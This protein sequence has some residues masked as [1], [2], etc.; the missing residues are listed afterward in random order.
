[1]ANKNNPL[2][3]TNLTVNFLPKFYQ[4]D[5]NKK[6]L[7]ATLDQL[8]QP[9]SIKKINGFVGRENAKSSTGTDIYI[10]ASDQVRQDYQLEPAITITDN[11]GNQTFFK[12]YI[13]YINQINTFGGNTANH[14]R[15]NKQEFYSWDPHIDWD[16]FVNFQNYYWVPYGPDTIRIQGQQKAVTSTYT[17][18]IE[19]ELSNNEY[20]FT[21][22]GFTRNPVLKLYR[23]QTYTFEINSPSNPFSIKTARTP[24]QADRYLVDT[25]DNHGVEIGT[26]T[27]TVPLD[28][29]T[30][31]FYQSESDLQL[32]GAIQVLSITADTYIDVEN[33]L[34]GKK[35]Y[36]LSNGTQLSNGMKLAFLGNVTPT[37]YASGEFFVEGVGVAIKLI[38][39]SR[40]EII[41]PYTEEKT[42]PFDSDKFD[43]QPFS[44]ATGYAGQSDYIVIDRG[45]ND[46][47]NWSR[48][49]RWFHKD[50]IAASSLYNGNPVNLDQTARAIRPIIEFNSDLKLANFGTTAIADVDVIDDY[51]TDAFS[52]IEGSFAYSVDG[53]SLAEGQRVIFTADPDILVKNKVFKVTFVNVLHLNSGS[54]QIHL[55][56]IS[57]PVLNQVALIK[58]GI[59]HQGSAFWYNGTTWVRGQLKTKVNQAPLFDV[60][61]EN[62]ISYGDNS[63]YNGSTFIG[64]TLFSYKLG[65]GT[66]DSALGFPLSYRNISNIGDIVFNF[67]LATD[68]FQYKQG[69]AL[70]TQAINVGY[71]VGQT[72]AGK[73]TY[74]NGW[75][76]CT[77]TNTQAAIRIYKN[78]GITNYFNIDIFDDITNLSDLVV[79]IY[80]N[81]H[82]LDPMVWTLID[83]P[84]YKQVQ[85]RTDIALSD[86]LTIRAFAA[87]PINTV[88]YYEIPVNLQNNPLNDIMGDFTLGEVSD[89]VNSIVDNLDTTFVGVFPGSGNLRDLGNV[90]QYGTKFV[91]HSGPMSLAIYHITSESNNVIRSVQQA[92]DDYNNFKRNFIKIASSLGVDGDTVTI[93]NLVLQK[94][95]KD[96]PK[97][98]PY[99]FSDMVPYGACVVTDLNV[100]DYRIKQ[101]PLTK[102]F[103]LTALSN[104]A[105]GV[106]LNGVQLVYEQDYRFLDTGFV[107]IDSSVNMNT[108]D[109][110]TTREY[111]STDGCFVPATPTKMGIW[112]K[113]APTIYTD[114]SLVTPRIMIQGHD[115]SQILAYGD[116]RDNLILELEKRIFNN[117]KVQYDT[118]IFDVTDIIPGYNRKTDYSLSEFNEVL[119]PNFY[120]WTALSGRDFT[121][122]LGT[123]AVENTFTYNYS[124]TVGPDGNPVPGYWRGIYRWLLDTDRPNL[125]PWE[126]LGFSIEPK[127][128]ATVYGV[129][130]YTG[131]NLPMWQDISDGMVRE[132]GVPAVKLNKYVKPFLMNHIPVDSNGTLLSPIDS[133]LVSGTTVFTMDGGFVF[134]DVNP[135]EAAWRRS[136]HYPFSILISAI[137][138][139]PA[140]TFGLLLD[141]ANIKRN[142]AGQLIYA[143]TNLR[144]RPTDIMLPSI[145]SSAT[146]V[147]TAGLVNYIVDHILNFVF[148][149]NIRSY[150]QYATDLDTLTSRISYRVGAFT[151]KEQFNL[152]LDS[153]TPLSTGSVFIPQEN[154]QVNINTS[155]P[156]KKITYSGVIITKLHSGYEVKGYSTTQPYFKYYPYLQTGQRI[157]VGG[158]SEGYTNWTPGQQY[159]ANSVILYKGQYYR[160]LSSTT[161]AATFDPTAFSYLGELPV[162][163]GANAVLRKL[164]D[165]NKPVVVP[166][167][168][169][170]TKIQ[171]VVDFLQGYGEWLTD[172]GFVFDDFNSNLNAV[173]NWENSAREFL[174][175]TTQNWNSGADT[176]ADWTP[177]E[178]VTYGTIVKY[179]GDYYSALYNIAATD[180]FDPI[181][182]SKLEGLSNVGSSVISLSPG[183][184]KLTFNT[185][186]AVVDNISNQ[187]YE[188]EIFKVDGTPL[189]P[190]F[191]DSYRENN[192]V[193]Y[194][195]RTTDGIY[196][197]SFYLIQNEHVVTIDNT[198][199]F[200]DV[201]YNPQSGY[202]QERIKVSGHV[203]IDWYGGLDVPG[204]IFDQANIKQWQ[205]WQDYALGD[206]VN[207]QGFYY[208]ALSA[209]SGTE[210]F[211]PNNW[212]QLTTKPTPKL[213]P[214]WTYKASQFTDF[215]SLDDDNFDTAQQNMAHHLIGYQKRQYLNN[216]IQDN[217]SEFKFF[218]GMIREKGTQNSLNKLFDV[219]SSDNKE[220]LK[221]YEEWAVRAGQYGASRAF[222]NIEFLLDEGAFRLNPQGF[223]LVT[224]PDVNLNGTFIIQ[225]KSTDVYLK[226]LGYDTKPWPLLTNY[227]PF[228]RSAGYVNSKEVSISLGYLSEIADLDIATINEGAYIW[229]AFEGPSWNLYRYTDIHMAV[230]NVTYNDSSKILTITAQ[231]LTGFVPGS[232]IG[233]AQVEK[234]KGFYQIISVELNTF[235]V[236]VIVNS[237]PSPFNQSSELVV[238]ALISQRTSSIDTLDSV[239][240]TKLTPGELIWTDDSGNGKWASW[241]FN[242]TYTIS[243]V[244]N[245]APQN[246]LR[247]GNTIAMNNKGTLA[248]VGSS[249]GE[250]ITYDKVGTVTPWVQRQIV[251]SPFIATNIV[252]L[253]TGNTVLNSTTVTMSS[254]NA[255]MV[256][257]FIDGPG[258][259]YDTLVTAVNNGISITISQKANATTTAS[260]FTIVTN[261]NP[262][263]VIATSIAFSADGTWMASGSPLAGY[264]VT[265]F[266]GAYNTANVY[267][268]GLIVSTGSGTSTTY[269]QALSNVPTNKPPA[270]NLAY[271]TPIYYLPVDSYGTWSINDSYLENTLVVYKSKVYKNVVP[272]TTPGLPSIYGQTTI[273]VLSTNGASYILTADTTAGL[274]PNYQIIFTGNVFGGILSGGLYYVSTVLSSTTFTITALQYSTSLAPVTTAYGSMQAT[275]Q[276]QPSPGGNNQW[277]EQ[278]T[279]AGPVGQGVISLYKKDPNNIYGLVDT[280]ISPFPTANE[281]FGSEIVFGNDTVYVS[282]PGYGGVGRVYK[283]KYATTIQAQSAYNPVGSTNSTIVVTSTAGVRAGMYVINPAFTSEQTVAQVLDS[284]TVILSGSPNSIPSGIIKFAIVGWG[285][286]FTEI[287]SGTQTGAAFGN[288]ISLSQDNL[289]LAIGADTGTIN[290]VL[291]IYKNTGTGFNPALPLISIPGTTKNFGIS[292]SISNDGTYIAV[293]DDS[294]TVGGVIQRGGVTVYKFNGTTYLPY[295]TLI[296]HQPEI[297][298]HFGNKLSFMNDYETLVVYSQYGDTIITTTFDDK[299]TTFDK[300]STSFVFTQTNSGRVD[301][302]DLYATKWV[303][304]ESLT[305]SN[306]VKTAG[307]FIRNNV[308][309]ILT[310]GTTDFTT[311]GASTNTIGVTFTAT[312]DGYGT[313]TAALVTNETLIDDG[314]GVGFAVGSNHILIGAPESIDQGFNSGKVYDYGKPNNTYTWTIDHSEVDKPDVTKIKQAF[315]YNRVTGELITHL[316]VIDIA[317]GKIPG[318]ADEEIMYKAFYDPAS[319]STVNGTTTSESSTVWTTKQVGQLWWDVRTA[320][321]IDAYENDPVY[322]NTNWNTL[323]TG[324]SIDIYEWVETKLK[325]SVW[326][327]QADTPAGLTNNI[328]G[329]SLYGDSKY[330]IKTTYNTVTLSTVTTYYFWVKNR[331]FTPSVPGRYMSAQDVSSLIANPRGQGYTYLALTGLDSFS[332]V[333]AKSYLK[334]NEVVL[335]V[336]YWTGDK[337]DQ[338]VHS[339]WN[340]ISDDP[341]TYIPLPIEQKWIDSLCGK[342]TAGREVPDLSLPVKLR[343]GIENRPRQGMFVNR[344]E[345][346]KQFVET[347]NQILLANQIVEEASITALQGYDPQPTV[348]SGLYDVTFPTDA[349]LVYASTGSFTRAVIVP[350]VADGRVTGVIVINSGK[351]YLVAPY[352]TIVGVGVGAK[353]RA[354]IN[355]KGQITG[356]TVIASGE[357]YSDTT[358]TINVRDYC[359]LVQSDSQANGNWSIYSYD[360]TQRSWARILTQSYDVRQ[361]WNYADW[362]G[363]YTDTTGKVIFTASQ[364]TVAKFSVATLTDLNGIQPAI[365]DI[366]KVRTTNAGGWELLYKYSNSTS[367]DWT[368]SY[369]TVGIQNGTIQLSSSLYNLSNTDLGFDNTIYDSNSYDKVASIE[370]RIILDTLKNKIFTQ[371]TSLNGAYSDLFFASVRYALSEQPYVDWIFKTSFVKAQHN[372]GP[373]NQPVTYQADN[374]ANFE[375]YVNEVKP[376]KTKVREYVSNYDSLDPAQ[377]PI[378]DFDLQPI[379]QNNALAVIDTF[380]SNGKLAT[381]NSIVQQYPW[382]FW[383]D[384]G[385]FEV[386]ELKLTSSGSKY[387]TE[388]QVIITSD[389]GSGA[390]A[391]AFISNEKINRIVLLTP[392]SGYLSAPKV[393]IRGGTLIDGTS[394]TASAI[395][396]NSVV[397]GT[398]VGIKFD[399]I[400]STYF[401]TQQS[402][403]E[404]FTGTGSRQQF[405]LVWGPDIKIGQSTVYIDNILALRDSYVM[406]VVKSTSLGY[407]TYSGIIQFDTAPKKGSSISVTYMIDPSL[408]QATDR[409]QYLYNSATGELG[410]DLSQ[411]MTGVDY[412]GVIVDGTGFQ[413]SNGWDSLPYYSDQWDSFDET[414]NDYS[415]VVG[416]DTHAFTLPYTP[417]AGVQLTLY[418][419]QS[420][421]DTY[422][423]DGITKTYLYSTADVA[424]YVT[425]ANNLATVGISAT[426][427][428]INRIGS[429]FGTILMISNTAGIVAG[430]GVVGA[431]F[432]NG[433]TVSSVTNST[434]LVLSIPADSQ[435]SGTIQFI[436]NV[437]GSATLNVTSTVALKPGDVVTLLNLNA[438]SYNTTV[439]SIPNSTTVT[440]SNIIYQTIPPGTYITF[441]RKLIQPTDVTVKTDGSIVLTNL[442]NSKIVA[443]TLINIIGQINPVRLDDP[444]Y[445]IKPYFQ[446]L[447]NAFA[448]DTAFTTGTIS[449]MQ[450]IFAGLDILTQVKTFGYDAVTTA[451]SVTA[452]A[453]TILAIPAVAANSAAV[454]T[455]NTNLANIVGLI[456]QDNSGIIPTPEFPEY[457]NLAGYS[458]LTSS[459]TV[460]IISYAQGFSISFTTN[461]S[462]GQ[463]LFTTGSRIRIISAANSSNYLEGVITSYVGTTLVFSVD[464]VS[465]S[466]TPSSWN[467]VDI[468]AQSY[469]NAGTLL[470]DNITFIQFEMVAYITANYPSATYDDAIFRQDIQNVV[471]S[472][473]YDLTYGGNSQSVQ[474]GLR[475]WSSNNDLRTNLLAAWPG[476]YT[477]LASIAQSVITKST[478]TR[479]QT[480]VAQYKPANILTEGGIASDSVSANLATIKSIV[481]AL[482]RPNITVTPPVLTKALSALQPVATAILN[483]SL[484][485]PYNRNAIVNTFLSNGL[486]DNSGVVSK[487]FTI[488][489]PYTLI[490]GGASYTT[491][492]TEVDDGGNASSSPTVVDDGGTAISSGFVVSNL[493][494]FTIRQIT[495]DGSIKP[496]ETDY[497]TALNGGDTSTTLQGV[498]AT[499]TGLNA[500]DII[501]DGDDLVTTTSSPAPEE[502]VPGQVVD[503]VAIKVFDKPYNGSATMR[504]DNFVANGTNKSFALSQTP[505][506]KGAVI[507]KLNNT[508]KTLTTDY[509]IDYR[510]NLVVF[511][512][513]PAANTQVSLFSVGFNGA[514]ILDIDHFVSNGYSTEIVS[515]ATWQENISTLVY[516]DG[517]VVNPEIFKTDSSYDLSNSIAFRFAVAPA[518]NALI[519]F[520]IVAGDQQ[521]FAITKVE[522]VATN[523][524]LTY[525]LQNR[526]GDSLPAES[527]MIVRVDQTILSAPNNSYFTIGGNRLNYSIDSTKFVPYS[528]DI[529]ALVVLVGGVTLRAGPDYIADLGGITIK[530]TRKI[531]NLY[532]GQTLVISVLTGA[533]YSY[534]STTGQITFAQA[535]DNT[536]VV[537]VISSYQHD[538][539]NIQRTTVNVI[540][541]SLLVPNSANYFY[542]QDTAGGLVALDRPVISDYYV[543][544]IKNSLLLTP[545]VDYK[546]ND[547]HQSITLAKELNTNDQITLMTFGSDILTPGIAYMQFKDMLNRVSYKRL[548]ISKQ[549]T[550]ANDLKWND[551]AIVLADAS[552]FEIPSP[553]NNKPGVVEIRGE[554]IEYFVKSGNTLSQLRRGTLGTGVFFNNF[555][556]TPVQDIGAG[557]TI[558]YKDTQTVTQII[559]DG[560]KIIPLDFVPAS[561]NAIEVFVGG[562][563]TDNEWSSGVAYTVGAIVK[564]GPYTYRCITAHTS[565]AFFDDIAKWTFFIG[566]IRLKKTPYKVFNINNAPNSPAGDV[567]FP[568]DFTVDGVTKQITLT[569]LLDFGIQVTVVQNTGVAWDN[570]TSVLYDAGKIS[571]FLRAE[572]G[573]WHTPYKQISITATGT[574]D[575]AGDTLDSAN[576]T[577]DQG[578]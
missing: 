555:A 89:H 255:S 243:D 534:N 266:L 256:G 455:I 530:L 490:D 25:I 334:S 101:Y 244:N 322:R 7:Q 546:L 446:Q 569:N 239:L 162:V 374:L 94:I 183:A 399:R 102:P 96:K 260:T 313:G 271:W 171:D 558:P 27:F 143:N 209:L 560:N 35:H 325:P 200:N 207:N 551:T 88:G 215:Y 72:F 327:T 71:L 462:A 258:V 124:D 284:R 290:G 28:A 199:I 63:V 336:E 378:T 195:P 93:T 175:W 539:L 491:L 122:P 216:I 108:G 51:T 77:A 281:N 288:S 133:G 16:K 167:G 81:G 364:F 431:G 107:V 532:K 301:I 127:W 160:T 83:T 424:P 269:W 418:R 179:N 397:R 9:G 169:E 291:N 415:V 464:S 383:L 553:A 46:A 402:K 247:F 85:L 403:T 109:V 125:C 444:N 550:L 469:I 406:Y 112:P 474:A 305:K 184:N 137:L 432:A 345:A 308:Y 510:N 194:S 480:A 330:S 420:N 307:N 458:G 507:V 204:F 577:F 449:N 105:V 310:L 319:Y 229:V 463:T 497:D 559:S 121:K 394:A 79:R 65:S 44:D 426:F 488:P 267:G 287:Y 295:Q 294:A 276:P 219:L 139:N 193:S 264:A 240:T 365:G 435:P 398:M 221:F 554:R 104:D 575:S 471:W 236:S 201:V 441:T 48:Y 486:P 177:A 359:A 173:S 386:I 311:I 454:A 73:P 528:V 544:V 70:L 246:Q 526:I 232:W 422:Q 115:G 91:Q 492:D 542:Y 47:N 388:P 241:M 8:Y 218:Q 15:L 421:T 153:K 556:G 123:F 279:Q 457:I 382:K 314:Y 427:T 567:T 391:R 460:A 131:D 149:N 537:Q 339:H 475:Y 166:Y 254:A 220:S 529:T 513:A 413:I 533:G 20:L 24:G 515:N 141:R 400:N 234:L 573:I 504:V 119:A 478:V 442:A 163:G 335:S 351:G 32:G 303:F 466:G 445:N 350:V 100:V 484:V 136:S 372:V 49:N 59:K 450:S 571:E 524:A 268:P 66:N 154:Y 157:N 86:V 42:I 275:Q 228:L 18:S 134:G 53:V 512:T 132:P 384:N 405:L 514:N 329:K 522:T 178:P 187:F 56:E 572:A 309:Q 68:T 472:L 540:G 440:L 262:A 142:R 172:Q 557:E 361:F 205:I 443:G 563:N 459:T 34:L 562:Y 333:N 451:A 147:Q 206:I 272:T 390:T 545:T 278:S 452:L 362:Y 321:V 561:A 541:T 429:L 538:I 392:G 26:I 155:S 64:T 520:V 318:P 356:A 342:D 263:T 347:A 211:N 340:I 10:E 297:N 564:Q 62:G 409:I 31:L 21:P 387:I 341:T 477:R 150:N 189:A 99:Y 320:K 447:I 259:P 69:T 337:T 214:N 483:A 14:A 38:S 363:S 135:V 161:A 145:Y 277:A 461:L 568:A 476:I 118:A 506:G 213:I 438:F 12:D 76:L 130:P 168:T 212:V 238:Y 280:I 509:T 40:L 82:R 536:H 159:V 574:F 535:Y 106:Y 531:Y 185:T 316:D 226:P 113:F 428:N 156:I 282:A 248:A 344:F 84:F 369:A 188:Y 227:K 430:M 190:L 467:I 552:N 203:S 439:L 164:W 434:T 570:K 251:A 498:Y 407:T 412:G 233:L 230:T 174:F 302:Y 437:V 253:T 39:T 283:L 495:S 306:P 416:A 323:A 470:F 245:S 373:L 293:A 196:G 176:W 138:L 222:E 120:K 274:A 521:T 144:V 501:V 252:A 95:N 389:S 348:I 448:Y 224:T 3:N 503:T 508:I 11:I 13:D 6:F 349:E 37:E 375:D 126:M 140:K 502:V 286:D 352:L 129:G 576:I 87:Q 401:I 299:T 385:G 33:E 353:V 453:N 543:W 223:Q 78:S 90:T 505:N 368:Q 54:R 355:T 285:Y 379:Y 482:G 30:L 331:K 237:F 371:H 114:T 346:L 485:P 217:V 19:R 36:K 289:T 360:P 152:L 479:L 151:S 370:L 548:S 5:S 57:S 381:N 210:K 425:V 61:D 117:I 191:L 146:R 257:G 499:A 202:R 296:P 487:T 4:S 158:I 180:V 393:E 404:T 358:T 292:T 481:T 116:Y 516:V 41:N 22:N 181:K 182:Y 170:F 17:V 43:T 324:A 103:V 465:G 357:G 242:P 250:L 473:I 300:N 493:D 396:G 110:I 525:T 315:L 60:V 423:S 148:S 523:G 338:N 23:G 231:D 547:D 332:L 417:A 377:L 419:K 265:D 494:Q 312:G 92:R 50:V 496:K 436:R 55:E 517:V 128:W 326:D 1:M 395:I 165:R 273:N 75:Q 80:V 414:F 433:Q 380:V 67:T 565:T 511:V 198:T 367:V 261:P 2:G 578:K 298:G 519:N 527:N 52:T 225:Q 354:T 317:Q 456:D 58:F 376:Y 197:A 410:K 549:T 29:P 566:N 328:S 249:F 111:D 343:Y 366:V 411:L 208:S 98:S 192:I 45:S 518:Q 468:D 489:T 97:T 186:L 304:S 270:S 408:M 74:K 235:T 500:D